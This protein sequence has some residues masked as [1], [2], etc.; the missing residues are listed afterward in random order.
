M[1]NPAAWLDGILAH[2]VVLGAATGEPRMSEPRQYLIEG[3]LGRG[4]F[5]SVYLAELRAYPDYRK[6][7]AL[8]IVKADVSD[9]IEIGRRTR[10]EARVLALLRHKALVHVEGLAH[11][12]AGWAVV[13][14]YV[15]GL[16]LQTTLTMVGRLPSR[17]AAQIVAEV[18]GALHAG[19]HTPGLDGKPLNLLHRDIKPANIRLTSFGEVKLLDFGTAR[20][21]FETREAA[22][23]SLAFGTPG[24]LAPERLEFQD[25]PASDVFSL[26]IVLYEMLTGARFGQTG[27]NPFKHEEKLAGARRALGGIGERDGAEL[28][29]L[30]F[31]MLSFE[32]DDRPIPRDVERRAEH[33]ASRLGGDSLRDWAEAELPALLAL[34]SPSREDP[35]VG[36]ILEELPG[37]VPSLTPSIVPVQEGLSPAPPRAVALTPAPSRPPA[38]TPLPPPPASSPAPPPRPPAPPRAAVPPRDRAAPP[39]PASSASTRASGDEGLGVPRMWIVALILGAFLVAGVGATITVALAKLLKPPVSASAG[40]AAACPDDLPSV[41]AACDTL[42][43]RCTFMVKTACGD[44]DATARCESGAWAVDLEACPPTCPDAAPAVG[45]SCA[46]PGLVCELTAS[47][48]CGLRPAKATCS[49]AGV[50][51]LVVEP[52]QSAG[53]PTTSKTRCPSAAPTDG[54]SCGSTGQRCSWTEGT[55]CTSPNVT[56][57]CRDG[58]W[59]VAATICAPPSVSSAKA[60]V[61]VSGD[62]L[63]QLAPVGGGRRVEVGQVTPGDYVVWADFGAGWVATSL[64]LKLAEKDSVKVQCSRMMG[65]CLR[66]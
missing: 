28:A 36:Q 16:D 32:A 4:G 51:D 33:I 47:T 50:W 13:L 19:L 40:P 2:D 49:A 52:C 57:T 27:A 34:N 48:S 39:T 1:V 41:G 63:V 45:D 66:R 44:R 17:P 55:I 5:G 9:I 35:L 30:M 12:S 23:R 8:K 21:Q 60:V 37:A 61:S 10:D 42:A 43:Q 62:A 25:G 31:E 59:D 29:R 54:S 24:Y 18:A 38:P 56:A 11:L 26:G 58:R 7:V 65:T 22:T 20:A 46:D 64:T 53:R 14:E 3:V 15:E 6:K